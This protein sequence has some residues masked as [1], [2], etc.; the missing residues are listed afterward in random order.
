MVG[1]LQLLA[2]W[3]HGGGFAPGI[4]A[5]N[6]RRIIPCDIENLMWFILIK[7]QGKAVQFINRTKF[8]Q[9][10]GNVHQ[11]TPVIQRNNQTHINSI[12]KTTYKFSRFC[13]KL[14]LKMSKYIDVISGNHH[15]VSERTGQ[16]P[17]PKICVSTQ[18]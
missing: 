9:I 12:S 6:H 14:Y 4:T 3:L 5:V 2:N 15:T 1:D 10:S 16:N 17:G 11:P 8:M 18:H 7:A 13:T